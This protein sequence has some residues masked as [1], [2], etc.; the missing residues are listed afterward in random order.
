MKVTDK[1]FQLENFIVDKLNLVV[2]RVSERKLD[3]IF[4]IDGDEGFGKTGL[5]LQLAYYL[6]Y[7]TG[8][9]FNLSHVFFD[10]NELITYV[11]S[12][13]EKIIV[14]DEAALGGL[15]SGWQSRVQQML[16]QTLMTCRFRKHIIFFNCPKFYRLNRYFISDRAVGLFHVYSEDKINAG[17]VAYYQ[18]ETLEKMIELYI[19]KKK[20]PYKM[21]YKKNL[22]GN[23][24]DTFGK[25]DIVDEGEYDNKKTQNTEDMLARYSDDRFNKKLLMLQYLIATHK[26]LMR[27]EKAKICM[28]R[29]ATITDWCRIPEKY[30]EILKEI[31]EK[32]ERRAQNK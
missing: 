10:P 12:T 28:V 27:K 19:K 3:A 9:E 4:V 2:E 15:A 1:Q 11:N 20:K 24:I 22:R 31:E 29:E 14:W 17:K 13:K 23:F 30:P 18:N 25:T 26:G 21:Y 5:S 32:T 8:R 7:K 6:A 16:I